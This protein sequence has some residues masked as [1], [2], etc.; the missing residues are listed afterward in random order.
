LT[1][2]D[3]RAM[4]IPRTDIDRHAGRVVVAIQVVCFSF[5]ESIG[6]TRDA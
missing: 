6:L 3:Q 1:R 5:I 4:K 2:V